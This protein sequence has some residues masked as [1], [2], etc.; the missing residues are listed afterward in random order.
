[1]DK[2]HIV[3]EVYGRDTDEMYLSLDE[4]VKKVKEGYWRG[5]DGN[6]HKGYSFQVRNHN[7]FNDIDNQTGEMI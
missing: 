3:I 7:D 6:S 4:V 5:F 1:M 2:Q